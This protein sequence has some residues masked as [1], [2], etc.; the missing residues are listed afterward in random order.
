MTDRQ[1]GI[2]AA[3]AEFWTRLTVRYCARHIFANVRGKWPKQVFKTLF[4]SAARTTYENDFNNYMKKIKEEKEE[5]YAYL[6]NIN[7]R[8]WARHAFSSLAKSDHVTNNMTESWNGWLKEFRG[9]PVLILMEHIRM[10]MMRRLRKRLKEA[11]TWNGKLPPNIQK[12]L[13]VNRQEGR[14]CKVLEADDYDFEVLD[15][16]TH[17]KFVVDLAKKI[18]GCGAYQISGIPCKH[19]MPCIAIRHERSADYVDPR[20]TVRAYIDTYSE[21]IKPLPDKKI[22]PIIEGPEIEPPKML[23]QV[24]RP[25][26]FARKKEPNELLGKRKKKATVRCTNC[27]I[28]GHN[29]RSCKNPSSLSQAAN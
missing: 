7:K 19:V 28:L 3:L 6:E 9:S 20:L 24:S 23:V 15:D 5:A 14:T 22:W 25:K 10:K 21:S 13:N 26:T 8:Q 27:D 16:E 12:K 1:K 4:W 11:R 17:E 18:C 29:K 2:L